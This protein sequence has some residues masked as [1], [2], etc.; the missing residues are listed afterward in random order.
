MKTNTMNPTLMS[1]HQWESTTLEQLRQNLAAFAAERHWEQYHTPR[2]VLLALVG[3]VGELSEL[4]QWK[5]EVKHG[6]PEFSTEE[7]QAVAEELSDVLLYLVR[8]ADACDI[9]L[10]TAAVDKIK[11]NAAKYPADKCRGSS[12][13]YTAYIQDEAQAEDGAEALEKNAKGSGQ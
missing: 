2:N 4:F 12:A 3:E 10:A 6:L 13:K 5:G 9:D 8:M 11:K 7:K 1:S